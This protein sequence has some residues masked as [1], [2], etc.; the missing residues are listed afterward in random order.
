MP[1]EVKATNGRSKSLR[2]LIESDHYPDIAFGVKIAD[3]N[4]GF[5]NGINTIPHFCA[6]LLKEWLSQIA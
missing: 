2:T 4:I 6:F 3:C 1:I 5:E